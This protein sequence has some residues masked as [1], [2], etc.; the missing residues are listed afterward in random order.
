MCVAML[1]RITYEWYYRLSRVKMQTVVM[2]KK[3]LYGIL[4]LL[5]LPAADLTACL[6]AGKSRLNK[7]QQI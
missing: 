3:K 5:H 7:M 1:L 2:V 6:E 4:E